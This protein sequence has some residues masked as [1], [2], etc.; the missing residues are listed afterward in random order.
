ML[1]GVGA[2]LALPLLEAM[3]PAAHPVTPGSEHGRGPPRTLG[4]PLRSQRQA[5]GR[6]DASVGRTTLVLPPTL[7]PLQPFRSDVLVL[8]GLTWTQRGRTAT[9]AAI[10]PR[11][12]RFPDRQ[13]PP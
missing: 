11:H 3:L 8:S 7:T 5:H 10:T 2:S 6:L 12:G 1:R 9:A 13:P 4:V